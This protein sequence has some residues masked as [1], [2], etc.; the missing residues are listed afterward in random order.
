MSAEGNSAAYSAALADHYMYDETVTMTAE[1]IDRIERWLADV[2]PRI[3]VTAKTALTCQKCGLD[4][5][6][7]ARRRPT[8]TLKKS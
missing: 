7:A 3:T 2:Q 4:L 1:D 6:P 5:T 8:R